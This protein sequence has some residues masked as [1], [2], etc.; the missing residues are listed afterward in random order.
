MMRVNGDRL[1]SDLRQLASFGR[2]KTGVDRVALSPADL[3][4]RRWLMQRMQEAGLE[5][6]MDEVANVYGRDPSAEARAADRLAY[7]YGSARRMARWRARRGLWARDR[8]CG[9]RR[10]ADPSPVGIDVVSF[11]DE[12][13]TYLAFLGSR[14]FCNDLT[15][16]EIDAARSAGVTLRSLLAA[17]PPA[18][19]PFRID[20]CTACLLSGGAHRAG[21]APRTG[22]PAHWHC[23]RDSRDQA[24]PHPN[25]RPSR[26]C[27]NDADG[28]SQRRGRGAVAPWLAGR[29]RVPGLG[30]ARTRSGTS[31]AS[32]FGQARPM[33]CR[34]R[35]RWCSSSAIPIR[36]PRCAGARSPQLGRSIQSRS[37]PDRDWNRWP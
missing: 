36:H 33:W 26:S 15:A 35:P 29:T 16:A 3:E 21:A 17:V 11:Q 14:T 18:T 34:T 27:G 2:F 12:E 22:R 4:A 31:A 24:I 23:H 8:P 6:H 37:L 10:A 5:P 30:R 28:Q 19:N 7:R 1:L 25:P 20:T 32:F 9:R 13:G